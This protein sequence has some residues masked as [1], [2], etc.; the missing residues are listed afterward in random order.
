MSKLRIASNYWVTPNSVLNNKDLS[1]KAKWLFWYLQ[2]KPNWWRFSVERIAKQNNDWKSAIQSWLKE[3]ED[4]WLLKRMP[5][6]DEKWQR[7]WYEYILSE[8]PL[9][10]NR[11]TDN[12]LTENIV[13]LSKK[14]NSN[15]DIVKKRNIYMS[16]NSKTKLGVEEE[17]EKIRSVWREWCKR[18]QST[19]W[20]KKTAKDKYFNVV[21]DEDTARR[22]E[23]S[24]SM[25]I[26]QCE[27]YGQFMKHLVTWINQEGREDEYDVVGPLSPEQLYKQYKSEVQNLETRKHRSSVGEK[28]RKQYGQLR[29]DAVKRGNEMLLKEGWY[30]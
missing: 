7:C 12:S 24:V 15:K 20:S 9:T 28:Y 25:Y 5:F 8:N 23:E 3:L 19:P 11:S 2:S 26:A 14:D 1:L 27:K 13:T 30:I 6:K 16:E 4:A 10:E 21:N 17:F 18:T 22:V 29:E